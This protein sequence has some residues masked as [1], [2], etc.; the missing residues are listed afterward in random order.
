[1]TSDTLTAL[2]R[3][4]VARRL[5]APVDGSKTELLSRLADAR[6]LAAV[7]EV[8]LDLR[9]LPEHPVISALTAAVDG[10]DLLARWMRLER[11]GHSRNRTRLEQGAEGEALVTHFAVDDITARR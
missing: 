2:V 10:R 4:G 3:A 5:G 11:F 7:I 1:M 9:H 8:G 6:G